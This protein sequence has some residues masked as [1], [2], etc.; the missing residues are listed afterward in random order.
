MKKITLLTLIIGTSML[1]FAQNYKI[2]FTG[3]GASTSVEKV[4][5]QNLTQDEE[6]ELV[7]DEILNI[8]FNVGIEDINARKSYIQVYPN[9]MLNESNLSFNLLENGKAKIFITDVTGKKISQLNT[10]LSQGRHNFKISGLSEGL[11]FVNVEGI[12]FRYSTKLVSTSNSYNTCTIKH[13]STNTFSK[14]TKKVA[15]ESM[16]QLYFNDGDLLLFKGYSG[17]YCTVVTAY[18]GNDTTIN[19]E[20]I[21]CKDYDGNNYAVVKIGEQ[22]WMA[23]HLKSTHYRNGEPIPNVTDNTD[24]ENTNEGAYCWYDN[25][26]DNKDIYGALYNWYTVVNE[27]NIAPE[28][29][30]IATKEE[31]QILTGGAGFGSFNRKGGRLKATSDLWNEPNTEATNA[32]GFTAL[33]SGYR[34]PMDG[35]FNELG[36]SCHGPWST[37][38]DGPQVGW[39]IAVEYNSNKAYMYGYYKESGFIIRCIK[40]D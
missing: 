40:E 2:N 29:W 10:F 17:D 20:F 16:V 37:S 11:Y 13:Q 19:F 18:P 8:L 15:N 36:I 24:W 12:N 4:I 25:D 5:V 6:V 26:E 28:G 38:T 14:E 31:L 27:N 21:E 23:E 3:D 32:T 30:R 22:T 34:D 9:P 33:P 35:T 39:Y 1:L 7:G